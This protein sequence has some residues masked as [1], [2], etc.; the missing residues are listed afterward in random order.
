[1]VPVE[2]ED[3]EIEIRRKPNHNTKV[4]TNI[5]ADVN[6][7]RKRK[8]AD[9]ED[10]SKSEDVNANGTSEKPLSKWKRFRRECEK[11]SAINE[12]VLRS[13]NLGTSCKD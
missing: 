11:L 3:D 1:M 4:P 9:I 2:E 7:N 10:I 6:A 12:R 8:S 5:N 13:S